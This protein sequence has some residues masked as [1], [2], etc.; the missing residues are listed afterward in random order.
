MN[1]HCLLDANSIIKH[2]VN[3][4]G[5]NI[6]NYLFDKSPSAVINISNVQIAEVVSLFYRF[7]REGIISSDKEREEFKDT[8]FN[9]IRIGKITRYAF[10]DEH[11]LDFDVYDKITSTPPPVKK[12]ILTF[13]SK[14]GGFVKELK[15]IA[16]TGD[17]IML[18]IMRE[19][20]FITDGN[21]YLV[22]CDGHVLNVAKT[23]NLKVIHPEKT[24]INNIPQCLDM[25]KYKRINSPVLK[26]ICK[27]CFTKEP[28]GS[29][30]TLDACEGGICVRKH[31]NFTDGRSIEIKLSPINRDNPSVELKGEIVRSNNWANVIKFV[32]PIP[33]DL[34]SSITNN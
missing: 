21:C 18:M 5:S 10:V 1:I 16:D 26:V 11:L 6:I 22:T 3:L 30:S 13:I 33:S 24:K 20:N 7:H 12:P 8:F 15:D 31:S 19:I 17:A 34:Y 32:D 29:T 14:F 9:D 28:L 4:P 25:R 2:Y 27:D 23:L